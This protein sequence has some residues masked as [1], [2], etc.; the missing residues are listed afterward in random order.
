MG[1][2]VHTAG[3][4]SQLS[5]DAVLSIRNHILV[6]AFEEGGVVFDVNSRQSH[7]INGTGAD[8]LGLMDGQMTFKTLVN[9]LNTQYEKD[10]AEIRD[11]ME[12]FI[13]DLIQR[14]WIDVK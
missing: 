9:E 3:G 8:I 7:M 12:H 6:A 1:S 10:E 5:D 13:A 2:Q 14:D 11:D 4:D